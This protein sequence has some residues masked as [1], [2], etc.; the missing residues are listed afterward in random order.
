MTDLPHGWV[1]VR[2][3][4]IAEVRLG[5]QRSPKNHTGTHMRPYLRAANVD[6]GGL[7]LDDVKEMNFTDEEAEVYRLFPGD[8]IMSEASG[9]AGHVGKPALWS[10]EIEDCCFQNT[11]IRVRSFGV[12][13]KFLLH[14]FRHESLRGAFVDDVRGV[15]IHHLGSKR[16]TEWS[17]SL[18]SLAEQRRIVATLEDHL[19]RLDSAAR[20]VGSASTKQQLLTRRLLDVQLERLTETTRPLL[21]IL[22]EPLTNGRS[23]PTDGDGFPVLR[24]TALRDGRLD[25]SERKGGRWTYAEAA[26]FLVQKD[27]FFI[28]RGNG[29]LSLVG[30]GALV[31][32]EPD[33]VAF[34]DTMVRIRVDRKMM[35]PQFL[36]LVWGSRMVRAQ[37]EKSARTTAG[38]YKINQRMIQD[39]RIPVP[40]LSVQ[41]RVV[42]EV[43]E[44]ME[45]LD[46]LRAKIQQTLIRGE[47]M[48]RSLL[49]EAF[50]GRLV[51]QD[52][53]DEPASVLLERIRAERA[54][55]GSVRRAR[56]GKG[57]KA[58]QKETLL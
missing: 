29:S 38:I 26:P 49:A 18:P 56:R 23:V 40:E 24:L 58:P 13:P 39:I 9:S 35:S 16:L 47:G 19:C 21:S 2:L 15:G 31:E 7:V 45:G 1:R 3:D 42:S 46:R 10:G 25:L 37:I 32:D 12:D 22:S 20:P 27:D 30:R 11:L 57:E 44:A 17:I 50:A 8:I 4:E 52:P 53:A 33:P 51:E 48:R 28:S 5:R 54:A 6:W 41:A 36:R 55:R 43:R 14:F 34:P